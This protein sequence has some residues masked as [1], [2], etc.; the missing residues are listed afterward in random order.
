MCMMLKLVVKL[1]AF[2]MA[3][4]VAPSV[5]VTIPKSM[6]VEI[7]DCTSILFGRSPVHYYIAIIVLLSWLSI[8]IQ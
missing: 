2:K 5:T 8:Y 7:I 6:Y 4:I 3:M 1:V